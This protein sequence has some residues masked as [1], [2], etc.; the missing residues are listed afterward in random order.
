[1]LLS[2]ISLAISEDLYLNKIN[3]ENELLSEMAFTEAFI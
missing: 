1:M 3:N 2:L